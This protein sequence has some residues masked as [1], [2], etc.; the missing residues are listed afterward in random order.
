M[1]NRIIR[2]WTDSEKVNRLSYEAEVLFIRLCMKADDYGSFHGNVKL[3]KAF[4]FPLRLDEVR[5]ADI[6]RWMAEC[7][8]AGLIV[9]YDAD[10]KPFVR[11]NNFGQRMRSM[12]KRFP[13]LPSFEASRRKSPQVA[14][15]CLPEGEDEDEIEKEIEGEGE[16]ENKKKGKGNRGS[17]L[18]AHPPAEVEKFK[19]FQDW[20]SRNTPRVSQMKEPFTIEQF[21]KIE[22]KIPPEK[23]MDLLRAMHNRRKLFDYTSAYLTLTRWWKKDEA[24]NQITSDESST[25]KS[26]YLRK[27]QQM[28]ERARALSK[29]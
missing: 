9:F 12:K 21:L 23:V 8:K 11:I 28:E 6:S 10:N 27:R 4:L 3:I 25:S 29:S 5:E 16:D 7:Q 20:I 13:D 2:D 26:E 24:P 1:A 14:A 15:E 19:K 17:K 22:K 18:P